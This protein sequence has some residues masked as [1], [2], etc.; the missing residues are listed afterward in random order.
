MLHSA[1]TLLGVLHTALEPSVQE[2][3][4]PVGTGPVEATKMIRGLEHLSCEGRLQDLALFSLEKRRLQE[5]LIAAF[6]YLKGAYKKDGDFLPRT[7]ET[8]LEA[9]F[10]N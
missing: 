9:K 10:L 5:D 6:Q 2:R 7:V 3:C 4:G 8:G 1:E